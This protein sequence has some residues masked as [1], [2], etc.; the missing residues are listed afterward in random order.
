MPGRWRKLLPGLWRHPVLVSV[1]LGLVGLGVYLA[2]RD[3]RARQQLRAAEQALQQ[4]DLSRA[5]ANLRLCLETW[6][7][8][9]DLHY[10]AARTARRAAAYDEAEE[11]LRHCLRLQGPSE[12]V[13]LEGALL[14]AQRGD[15]ARDEG[16][17]VACVHQDH[18]DTLAILEALTKGYAQTYRLPEALRC[19]QRWVQRQPNNAQALLWRG[20]IWEQLYYPREALGD[21]RRGVDLAPENDEGRL[22]PAPE[23]L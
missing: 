23:I 11:H 17:L 20:Q 5:L 7:D 10:L 16:Y 19:V 12:A 8:R 22:R 13:E 15:L 18:P 14:R 1:G 4:E 21:Y 9:A 2:S 6:P 3:L